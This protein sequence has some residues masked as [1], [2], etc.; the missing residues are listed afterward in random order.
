MG[1]ATRR[2]RLGHETTSRAGSFASGLMAVVIGP[3]R[4]DPAPER[5]P[6]SRRK[7]PR[8]PGARHTIIVSA[9]E[10][11]ATALSRNQTTPTS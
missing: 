11:I 1:I 6:S 7:Q 3:E 2:H 8:R 4:F 10:G 5:Q 9:A